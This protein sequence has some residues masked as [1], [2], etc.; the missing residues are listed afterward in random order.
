MAVRLKSENFPDLDDPV[1]YPRLAEH[2]L[3]MLKKKGELKSFDPGDVLYAQGQRDAPFYVLLEGRVD[4]VE[5]ELG[6]IVL[7]C[8]LARRAWHEEAG[9]GVLRLIAERGSRRAFDVRDLLERN[10]LPVRF[11]DV[12]TDPQATTF[13]EWLDIPREETPILVN[14]TDILRNPSAAQVARDLGLRAEIDG[15]RFDVVV[16]GAGP[17]G[18]AAAVYG[19]SEGL[20]TF[21]AEAWA[22][23][24]QAGTSSRIENYLGFPTGI[25]GSDLTRAATLQARRFDAVFS[26]FHRAVELADGPEGLVRVDLDDGQHVLARTLVMA[27]G[28]RWRE[29]PIPGIERFRGAGVYHAAMPADNK[30]YRDQDVLV[31]GGGNSAGQ[32]AMHMAQYAR[33]VRVAVRGDALSRT[34]SRYLVDRI[35]RSSRIEVLTRTELTR[36]NGMSTMESVTLRDG[37][38]GSESD[39]PVAAVFVMIGAEP[40]TE[41][42]TAMLG[43]DPAGYLLCGQGAAECTGHLRWPLEERPPHLLETVRPGVFAA[44]DVRAGAA[45]RVASAVGD[46]ALTV[47]FVHDVLDV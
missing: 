8:M 6:E 16:L 42:A 14:G 3:E 37:T 13:L 20:R 40:C 7:T 35:E 30:R 33:S 41:A 44:G 32:A 28:A 19:G 1:L 26:S 38:S 31:V 17:A 39:V 15:Q 11:Y 12:D 34:M 21:V 27:T 24:G 18:L 9:H 46:G 22:P 45:N 4:F 29:L 36:I 43:T 2:K 23:G 25:S 5:P 47:R 10:L